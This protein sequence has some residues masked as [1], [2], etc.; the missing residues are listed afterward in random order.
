[1]NVDNSSPETGTEGKEKEGCCM[2]KTQRSGKGLFTP[3][4]SHDGK[5]WIILSPGEDKFMESERKHQA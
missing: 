3:E 5:T 2:K 1:M 4:T